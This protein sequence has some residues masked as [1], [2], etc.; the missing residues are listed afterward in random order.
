MTPRAIARHLTGWRNARRYGVPAAMVATATRRR[1][2]GDWRG[3]A[4]AARFDVRFDLAQVRQD[5]GAELAARVEDDLRHLAPDLVRWHLPR[6]P[7]VVDGLFE[8]NIAVPLARY[9]HERPAVLWVRDPVLPAAPA[10]GRAAADQSPLG[11]AARRP[12]L[13]AGPPGIPIDNWIDTRDLWDARAAPGL[14][15][16]ING[17]DVEL[18]D[19]V[20]ALQD[21]GRIAEAWAAGGIARRPSRATRRGSRRTP[22]PWCR[23]CGRRSSGICPLRTVRST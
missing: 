7:C 13:R 14:G 19:R 18:T 5:F 17:G 22:T 2:A 12:G 23:R 9:D 10:T 4:E 16:R 20:V 6:E 21:A 3:A 8:P 1:L 11:Q 15:H